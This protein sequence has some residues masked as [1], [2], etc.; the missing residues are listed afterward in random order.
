M[1][2]VRVVVG[3]QVDA[4]ADAPGH[5]EQGDGLP[6]LHVS[7]VGWGGKGSGWSVAGRGYPYGGPVSVPKKTWGGRPGEPARDVRWR[8]RGPIGD[9]ETAHRDV[10]DAEQSREDAR[11]HPRTVD[12]RSNPRGN[13]KI[14][15]NHRNVTPHLRGESRGA[16]RVRT[17]L[18]L[19]RAAAGH[20]AAGHP[21]GSLSGPFG[22][23]Q[24]GGACGHRAS[25]C[26]MAP[27]LGSSC[28]SSSCQLPN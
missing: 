19:D 28:L 16:S 24:Q 13:P 9:R 15:G 6:L 25:E 17:S 5:G 12:A 22:E 7:C 1:F 23:V 14:S 21:H 8:R 11:V 10:D 3:E 2:L 26:G 27:Y 4:G 20:V 18:L